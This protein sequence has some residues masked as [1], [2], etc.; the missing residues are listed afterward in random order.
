MISRIFFFLTLGLVAIS[1][2]KKGYHPDEHLTMKQQDAV[3]WA[4]IRYVARAPE[5][6]TFQERFYKG[7]D[8]YY[9]EQQALHKLDAFYVIGDTCFFMIS[10]RAPSLVEKRVASA[11]KF[12]LSE[13]GELAYYKEV[14]RT[15][16]MKPKELEK[17]SIFLFDRLVRN[18]NLKIFERSKSQ[19]EYIEFPDETNYFDDKDRV[20]K[21]QTN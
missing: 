14:F 10:R 6:L 8:K 12:V 5:G 13:N 16:K 3:V 2:E 15:F 20:W 7:Y 4:L 1:C 11:G 17:K 21:Q 19:E 18:E 9:R